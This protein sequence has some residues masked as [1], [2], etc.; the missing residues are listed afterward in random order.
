MIHT[1]DGASTSSAP[2]S[3][4]NK[5]G[6]YLLLR[7][8][9]QNSLDESSQKHLPRPSGKEKPPY[10]NS[11]HTHRAFDVMNSMRKQHLLCDVVLIADGTEVPAH[12]MVLASCSPYFYAMFTSFEE[13][14]QDRIT[15]QDIDPQ[16]LQLLIDYVYSAEV[17]VLLPAANLLQ[18][19]DVRDACCDFL[20]AQLHPSNC[21]GIRAFA[22]L[23]GCIELL[24]H[25][26]TYIEQHF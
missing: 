26:D 11:H 5:Q 9:S 15:L 4:E 17:Q 21:L 18:L 16:A 2:E 6:S 7:Y 19:T 23:H 10:R 13:S 14:R 20:Q 22:D 1:M 12:K 8:A 25:A 24:T 3:L